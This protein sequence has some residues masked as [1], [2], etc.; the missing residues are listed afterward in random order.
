MQG[1]WSKILTPDSHLYR[2][3]HFMKTTSL[4]AILFSLSLFV[5]NAF[6]D[7]TESHTYQSEVAGIMCSACAAKIKAAFATMEGV[8]TVSVKPG[9]DGSAP[10]VEIVSTSESLT[11]ADAVK[12]LGKSA[13]TFIVQTF[14]RQD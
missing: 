11:Q 2:P 9:K 7:A 12:S 13:K 5:S 8:K 6:A 14:E 10:R 1:D 4:I 3:D